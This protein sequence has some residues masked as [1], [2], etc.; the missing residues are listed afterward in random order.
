MPAASA[1]QHPML[2]GRVVIDEGALAE[3]AEDVA[4]GRGEEVGHRLHEVGLAGA[5]WAFDR[6]A[7]D[8]VEQSRGRGSG[9]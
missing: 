8:A 3:R 5:G 7:D 4:G 1:H 2:E 6:E 9:R